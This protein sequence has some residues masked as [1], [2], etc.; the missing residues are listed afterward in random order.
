MTIILSVCQEHNSM[1]PLFG[2][3]KSVFVDE[4]NKPFAICNQFN[5]LCFDE[6]NQSY[7]V[8]LT[9]S[10]ICICLEDLESIYPTHNCSI[11]NGLLFIPLKL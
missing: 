2:L 8:T 1:L 7:N 3:I 11:S 4:M 9:N 6:H 10:L 5:T